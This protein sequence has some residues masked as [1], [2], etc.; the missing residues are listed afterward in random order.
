MSNEFRDW[1]WDKFAEILLDA[2]QVDKV[3]NR[4][5]AR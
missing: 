2:N 1:L 3:I 5:G 4:K